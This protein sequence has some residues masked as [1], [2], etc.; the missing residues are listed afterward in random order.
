MVLFVKIFVTYLPH[1]LLIYIQPGNWHNPSMKNINLH[2]ILLYL[3]FSNMFTNAISYC[4]L[5]AIASTTLLKLWPF[6]HHKVHSNNSSNASS[7]PVHVSFSEVQGQ[8]DNSSEGQRHR[9]NSSAEA[10]R[11]RKNSSGIQRQGENS[12]DEEDN[13]SENWIPEDNSSAVL[14]QDDYMEL[15]TSATPPSIKLVKPE[16]DVKVRTPSSK[17]NMRVFFSSNPICIIS[18]N[19]MNDN[20]HTEKRCSTNTK[21]SISLP[22]DNT[23]DFLS[24]V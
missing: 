4:F 6:C 14:R 24:S 10:Q 3:R 2:I 17:E 21:I 8:G 7:K 12:F 5:N 18:T 9:G 19:S 11:Q 20:D 23:Q 13:S 1:I 22:V 16:S 15:Q